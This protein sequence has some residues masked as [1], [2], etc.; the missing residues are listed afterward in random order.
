LLATGRASE[1]VDL[2]GGRVLAARRAPR[3]GGGRHASGDAE[4][5]RAR[6]MLGRERFIP[7]DET[8]SSRA[9][10]Y[11]AGPPRTLI[12][13]KRRLLFLLLF[14]G[15]LVLA[16]GGWTVQGVRRAFAVPATA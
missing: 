15:L 14:A 2:G 8:G 7:K 5:A 4:R 6:R 1:I 3:A 12:D 10:M 9:P 16:C 11:A 13:M